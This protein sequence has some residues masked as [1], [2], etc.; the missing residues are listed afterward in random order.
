MQD[1]NG[2]S[3]GGEST[4]V[5]KGNG[6]GS[7]KKGKAQ[8]QYVLTSS[9]D[10]KQDSENVSKDNRELQSEEEDIEDLQGK[11]KRYLEKGKDVMKKTVVLE[12]QSA[13]CNLHQSFRKCRKF[14]IT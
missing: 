12:G 11:W 2:G 14:S 3:R 4:P 9:E 1:I 8:A 13:V 10:E 7:G 6:K 5:R